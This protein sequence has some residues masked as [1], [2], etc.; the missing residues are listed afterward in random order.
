MQLKM[1][2]MTI[3]PTTGCTLLKLTVLLA[4]KVFT[5]SVFSENFCIVLSILNPRGCLCVLTPWSDH[6]LNKLKSYLTK[7]N[8]AKVKN[9]ILLQIMYIIEIFF[10]SN[11]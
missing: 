4:R 3:V 11:V 2:K 7:E 1:Y 9:E 6:V 5:C 8:N 10:Y